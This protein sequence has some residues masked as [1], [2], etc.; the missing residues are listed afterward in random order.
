MWAKELNSISDDY[1]D[2]TIEQQYNIF[3]FPVISDGLSS[4]Y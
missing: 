3:Y 2:I 4:K 1:M